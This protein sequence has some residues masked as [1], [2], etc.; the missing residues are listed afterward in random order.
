MCLHSEKA[1][2]NGSRNVS[3]RPGLLVV[4]VSAEVNSHDAKKLCSPLVLAAD[5]IK[6]V[7]VKHEMGEVADDVQ[8]R[9][10]AASAAS[11]DMSHHFTLIP[12]C[13][14]YRRSKA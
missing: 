10:L 3:D 5:H 12:P 11:F 13:R 8:Y 4:G 1:D 7:P 9:S 14:Y 6:S 2:M